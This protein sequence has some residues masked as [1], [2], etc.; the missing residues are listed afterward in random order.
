MG[1]GTSSEGEGNVFSNAA[2]SFKTC[3]TNWTFAQW[4]KLFF[5][6]VVFWGFMVGWM[7]IHVYVMHDLLPATDSDTVNNIVM[8]AKNT[9]KF[10]VDAILLANLW[11]KN[12][13][14]PSD[15]NFELS[16]TPWEYDT[17]WVSE[18]S[19]GTVCLDMREDDTC[20]ADV[21]SRENKRAN[22]Q[23]D[24][25]KNQMLFRHIYCNPAGTDGAV[26]AG[27]CAGSQQIR[28]AN[29]YR[30]KQ[31][32]EGDVT[33]SCRLNQQAKLFKPTA[34]GT[35]YAAEGGELSYQ[36]KTDD[37]WEQEVLPESEWNDAGVEKVHSKFLENYD[38]VFEQS[39]PRF[40]GN[41]A[42][43]PLPYNRTHGRSVLVKNAAG[44]I[45]DSV[46]VT[47]ENWRKEKMSVT[48]SQG[49]FLPHIDEYKLKLVAKEGFV[50][51]AG[52]EAGRYN[53]FVTCNVEMPDE[54]GVADQEDSM[55][56]KEFKKDGGKKDRRVDD[57]DAKRF[58]ADYKYRFEGNN[59]PMFW[60]VFG[61]NKVQYQYVYDFGQGPSPTS[62]S[63]T[64]GYMLVEAPKICRKKKCRN[65]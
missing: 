4:A 1:K 33:I 42:G 60:R 7:S 25:W 10:S 54:A 41:A 8:G 24:N 32:T 40:A 47:S 52:A 63:E 12:N 19:D 48:F 26:T 17:E 21:R 35:P 9:D 36:K 65:D 56:I 30:L 14:N 38:L 28:I 27:E 61:I 39:A 37:V 18:G 62:N 43:D 51:P 44:E 5:A 22:A 20:T 23:D 3:C 57:E 6:L 15:P 53:V 55:C 16:G 2:K 34:E 58:C 29:Q 49:S 59:D 46:V 11:G 50:E 31:L 13:Q 45:T 64:G